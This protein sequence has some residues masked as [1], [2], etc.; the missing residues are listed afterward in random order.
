GA[1]VN[2]ESGLDTDPEPATAVEPTEPKVLYAAIAAAR[3]L[4]LKT[5]VVS[6]AGGALLAYALGWHPALVF[7]VPLVPVLVALSV[8][9][10]RTQLLP[11]W[12]ISRTYAVL[13]PL[14]LVVGAVT[15]EW[16]D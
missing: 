6:A 9:D 12:V 10:W 2:P 5:A 1:A 3:G 7:L 16:D 8:V 13:V 4:A 11:T 14:I 15:G